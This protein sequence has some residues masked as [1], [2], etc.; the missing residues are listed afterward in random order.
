[1]PVDHPLK[2]TVHWPHHDTMDS[3]WI[4]ETYKLQEPV[5]LH[6]LQLL[7]CNVEV[8]IVWRS[9]ANYFSLLDDRYDHEERDGLLVRMKDICAE[10][11]IRLEDEDKVALHEYLARTP[12]ENGE[13]ETQLPSEAS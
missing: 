2:Y 13:G 3:I 4:G 10:K 12:A 5:L 6:N 7:P 11:S 1:V 8:F 9:W